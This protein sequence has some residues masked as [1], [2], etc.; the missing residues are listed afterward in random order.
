VSKERLG[1]W[2][3]DGATKD[4][5][6]VNARW[7]P[8]SLRLIDGV[9]IHEV[10]NVPKSN[11]FLTEILRGDWLEN[12]R[13]DQVFQ[14]V[15]EPDTISAWHAHESTTDRIFISYGLVRIALYDNR[16]GSPTQGLVNDFRF[17][18]VRPALV[19]VPPR[20]WHGL[21]NISSGV[22]IVLNL[23]DRAYAYED[24]DHWRIPYGDPRFPVSFR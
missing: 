14:V 6:T 22:G 12:R 5:Q 23:V 2:L 21:H 17:G 4:R 24:P 1:E 7:T 3:I 11:G 20:V 13:V 9:E 8:A 18:T 10:L 15:L 16:E 19:V